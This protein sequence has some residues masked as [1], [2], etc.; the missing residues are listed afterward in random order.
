MIAGPGW[1]GTTPSGIEAVIHTETQ[2]GYALF[3]TQLFNMADLPNVSKIQAGYHAGPLSSF[4]HQST[5]PSPPAVNWPQP[6]DIMTPSPAIFFIIDFLFQ[7]CPPNPS[8]KNLLA[9]FAQLNIGPGQT[10]NLNEFLLEI[11]QAI[12]DGIQ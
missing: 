11:Q 1:S 12:H 3:R 4:L 2:F 6:A 8:E 7:F 9:R 10:F 5:P